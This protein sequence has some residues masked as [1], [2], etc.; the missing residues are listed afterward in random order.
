MC[1]A[2]VCR[3]LC[4]T[5]RGSARRCWRR[6]APGRRPGRPTTSHPNA[7]ASSAPSTVATALCATAPGIATR[8]TASSS[9]TWNCRPTPNISRMTPISASCS[10][11]RGVGDEARRVGADQ[12]AGE[13]IA[14]DRRQAEPLGDVAEERA[15]RRGP[16]V[17]VRMRSLMCTVGCKFDRSRLECAAEGGLVRQRYIPLLAVAAV[18]AF[19]GSSGAQEQPFRFAGAAC[20]T[21]PVLHC[22]DNDCSSDR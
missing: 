22:P 12:R 11:M 10:A 5:A 14:D 6:R 2:G 4:R 16:P 8:R 19:G 9:S 17:S 21:P 3:S 15:P 20:A 13:Q 7:R 18:F 1:P